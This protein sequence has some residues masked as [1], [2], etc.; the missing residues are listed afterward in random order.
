M[1]RLLVNNNEM[2]LPQ[3]VSI[4]LKKTVINPS[5]PSIKQ[6]EKSYSFELPLTNK[7][8][9]V[10]GTTPN[11]YQVNKFNKQFNCLLYFNDNIIFEGELFISEITETSFKVNIVVVKQAATSD[12][13]A[14]TK[15]NEIKWYAESSPETI[16]DINKVASVSN[17]EYIMPLAAYGLL[18]K[19]PSGVYEETDS[20]SD[21]TNYVDTYSNKN[22]IDESNFFSITDFPLSLNVKDIIKNIFKYKNINISGEFLSDSRTDGLYMSYHNTSDDND[23]MPYNWGKLAQFSLSGTY[24]NSSA[25]KGGRM[26]SSTQN[27]S[28]GTQ[29]LVIA[30]LLAESNSRITSVTDNK[31][32]YEYDEHNSKHYIYIPVDGY[33]LINLNC[34]THLVTSTAGPMY[35]PSTNDENIGVYVPNNS[36][37]FYYYNGTNNVLEE[38]HMHICS[39]ADY[40]PSTEQFLSIMKSP[41]INNGEYPT[42]YGQMVVDPSL[43]NTFVMG[44][45]VGQNKNKDGDY[46]QDFQNN[47][48]TYNRY[49][50][51]K[52]S[53]WSYD[54][55]YGQEEPVRTAYPMP[56]KYKKNNL[57]TNNPNSNLSVDNSFKI[58][59]KT[60]G[61]FTNTLSSATGTCYSNNY[62]MAYLHRGDRVYLSLVTNAYKYSYAGYTRLCMPYINVN[63]DINIRYI[64]NIVDTISAKKFM[65]STYYLNDAQIQD[66]ELELSKWLPDDIT[67]QTFLNDICNMFNCSII[68]KNENTYEINYNNQNNNNGLI[69][70]LKNKKSDKNYSIK[71]LNIPSNYNISFK[72]DEDEEGYD[73]QYTQDNSNRNYNGS[74]NINTNNVNG[75]AYNNDVGFSYCWYKAFNAFNKTI[76][77]PV[78]SNREVWK[79]D[80]IDGEINR[81]ALNDYQQDMAKKYFNLTYRLFYNA[82]GYNINIAKQDSTT[83]TNGQTI[84]FSLAKNDGGFN[85]SYD[86]TIE[87]SLL[88][89]LFILIKNNAGYLYTFNTYLNAVDYNNLNNYTYI[90]YND[91]L[92]LVNDVDN[93]DIEQKSPSKLTLIKYLK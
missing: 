91:D 9:R 4:K 24:F 76:Y 2:D 16:L 39:A 43:S 85:L 21:T 29:D 38:V 78:I 66:K 49:N 10:L 14:D 75:D 25:G 50:L 88:N 77:L 61:N 45:A 30:D 59:N 31:C 68:R 72:I 52:K 54:L 86:E 6:S 5:S 42:Q 36:S 63:F 41:N 47:G 32:F 51:V 73:E 11:L 3:N 55:S 33:Y 23:N 7:N 60:V 58:N 46:T 89:K 35:Y 81:N 70:K 26:Y 15:L 92:Y 84:T 57:T 8:V 17:S 40:D 48:A 64:N 12:L 22:I 20:V 28:N 90:Q 74:I 27:F 93:F 83:L 62:I 87:N 82:G 80:Y 65:N 34:D 69:Y 37:P 56:S 71:P 44:F 18:N 79:P 1:Y 67:I 19:F 53:G 13:F